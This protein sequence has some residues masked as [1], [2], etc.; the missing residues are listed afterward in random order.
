M[1]SAEIRESFCQF[2]ESKH[3][4]RVDSASLLPQSPG[5]LFTNA[6]MNQFVPYFLGTQSAPYSPARATDTQ[7]CIRAGGKHND[8]ED[9]GIDTYH[10]TFFEM[11]G[12]WSFGDYFKQEAIEWA[13]ELMI[14]VWNFPA[15]RLYATVYSPDK[16]A[17]DPGEFDQEAYDFWAK[18]FSKAGLDPAV[19]VINGDVKDNF[20]MMGETGPCGPC[21]ELHMDL[22]PAGDT[23]GKLV[24]QDSDQCI[25]LWNLV[26]IQY[27]ANED[28]SFSALPA[29]H[30][31]TGMGFERICSI[32]QGTNHFQDFNAKISNYNTDLFSP[33][34]AKLTELSGHTYID[35]YP[36]HLAENASAEDK[37]DLDNAIAYRVIADHLRTLCCSIAD[38]I[39]PGN[40]GRNYVLRRILRRAVRYAKTLNIQGNNPIL[41]AV[42]TAVIDTL[43]DTF[44]ELRAKQQLIV[45]TLNREEKSFNQTLD[46]GLQRFE[47]YLKQVENNQ[48]SGQA[49]FE[50]Y[51]T[52][53]FPLDLTALMCREQGLKLDEAGFDIAMEQQ[54]ELARSSQNKQIVKAL[55]IS[56]HFSTDYTENQKS[57]VIATILEI[58]SQDDSLLVV[59]DKTPFY[60]EMGG[61]VSDSGTLSSGSISYD[62]QA[63]GK[64][65][66]AIFH[67]VQNDAILSVGD[68]VNL[69]LDEDKRHLIESHHSATHLLHWALHEVVDPNASQQGSFVDESR[70]RFDFN[71][72]ALKDSDLAK[73][74]TKV[75]EAIALN[76]PIHI[77]EQ[78]YNKVKDNSKIQQFFGDKYGD[79]VR[80][81]Q[82]GGEAEQLNGYAMELCG[83]SHVAHTGDIQSFY[84]KSEKAVAAGT[85]RIEAVCGASA[86]QWLQNSI[87][88][89][90]AS[91]T[92]LQEKWQSIKPQLIVA[93]Q[94]LSTEPELHLEGLDLAGQ[95]Q[96]LKQHQADWKNYLTQSDKQLKKAQSKLAQ[97]QAQAI[98]EELA[99]DEPALF[100]GTG[101]PVLLQE[102]LTGALKAK[103]SGLRCFIIQD[104]AKLHIGIWAGENGEAKA[105]FDE[106]CKGTNARGG[107]KG[108]QLRGSADNTE[109][110]LQF[111]QKQFSVLQSELTQ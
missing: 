109:T 66:D 19:H 95:L 41:S 11:L 22:S 1:T 99:A 40:S 7:K 42:A 37:S 52:F 81:V 8:L 88:T 98:L 56:S 49:A 64:V 80:V 15:E 83:G 62:V 4:T 106:V 63:V 27:N 10:H 82:I 25:E 26:F 86:Q 78:P 91:I 96:A 55:D 36:H 21:S 104:D 20:W 31:D 47:Q 28:G 50:L 69:N 6:G 13:W 33:I 34:F 54:K 87:D 73:L 103:T 94:E 58:H 76:S 14:D 30:V 74:E 3:H 75:R 60:V 59:T 77:S 29:C 43:A 107:G 12:N 92:E 51:D 90:S 71:S 57:A 110:N 18:L 65:N 105:V 39:Q 101:S 16:A 102:L 111:I 100:I 67:V 5:L 45:D 84:I 68:T 72:A 32:I 24:N 46:R 44:P 35:V 79:R 85:R 108:P 89:T 23:Q 61:Q 38:G 17:G 70:L 97:Q 53:G 48:F 2:F 9:V 93:E